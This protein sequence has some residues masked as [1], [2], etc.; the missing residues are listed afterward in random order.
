MAALAMSNPF[1]DANDQEH[2]GARQDEQHDARGAEH[3]RPERAV[4]EAAAG[5]Q[6]AGQAGS[7]SLRSRH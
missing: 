6:V 2:G 3:R 7:S 1:D 4:S 5:P